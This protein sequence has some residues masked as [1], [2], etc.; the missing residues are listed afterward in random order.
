M[1]QLKKLRPIPKFPL[2]DTTIDAVIKQPSATC[3]APASDF[4]SVQTYYL[5]SPPLSAESSVA[6]PE[7]EPAQC[8]RGQVS[9]IQASPKKTPA[10][11]L[12]TFR[13]R[14]GRGGR[15]LIDRRGR[16]SVST[17]DLDP[18]VLDRIRYDNDD[19]SE[20]QSP[21]FPIDPHSDR[22]GS[23]RVAFPRDHYLTS[24]S[25]QIR[26]RAQMISPP[27]EL[28][29]AAQPPTNPTRHPIVSSSPLTSSSGHSG[30]GNAP[31]NV[32]QQKATAINGHPALSNH[33]STMTAGGM[34]VNGHGTASFGVRR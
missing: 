32:L 1:L 7:D 16:A 30:V 21:V 33:H 14:L 2:V 18:I 6:S 10:R 29:T 28:S 31:T 3:M 4:C 24:I 11:N 15:I 20:E 8:R 13:R 34:Q 5:P 22:C 12:P 27:P 19:D 17:E 23:F 26:F 9:I 25:R